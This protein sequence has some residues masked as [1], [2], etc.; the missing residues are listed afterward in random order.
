MS[1]SVLI[2][3]KQQDELKLLIKE[4]AIKDMV[5]DLVSASETYESIEKDARFSALNNRYTALTGQTCL[6]IGSVYRAILA[7]YPRTGEHSLD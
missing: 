7:I 6:T 5:A 4:P 2:G 3:Q 1:T